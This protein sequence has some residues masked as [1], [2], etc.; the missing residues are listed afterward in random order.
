MGQVCT[1]DML[2]GT[3]EEGQEGVFGVEYERQ[4]FTTRR[5]WPKFPVFLCGISSRQKPETT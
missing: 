1:S 4:I 5:L 3:S 2:E